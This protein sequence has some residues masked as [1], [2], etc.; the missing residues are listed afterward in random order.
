LV[1]FLNI[2]TANDLFLLSPKSVQSVIINLAGI[3]NKRS[4][5]TILPVLRSLLA[6]LFTLGYAEKDVSGIVMS[7]YV[8][9]GSVAGYL[10]QKDQAAILEQINKE[11]KRTKAIILLAVKLGLRGCDISNLTFQELDWRNDKIT[12]LQKKTGTPLVLPLLADV[13]N[14]LMEYILYERPKRKDRYPYVFLR[15]QAPYNKITSAYSTC[16]KLLMKL[17]IKPVNSQAKGA[18]VFRYTMVH[19][20]LAVKT[21]HQVITNTLGHVSKESDKPYLSMEESMLRLCALDLSVVGTV[22]WEGGI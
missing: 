21:P 6:S 2:D 11:S 9:K 10:S 8:Q 13:G 4:M 14:A 12:L 5:A 17:G 18:H 7:G 20:L 1:S 22:S 3:C 16:S 19:R 15:K